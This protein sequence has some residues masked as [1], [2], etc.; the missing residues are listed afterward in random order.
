MFCSVSIVNCIVSVDYYLNIPN[1][2]MT[3]TTV[4]HE[5]NSISPKQSFNSKKADT[6]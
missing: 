6:G 1:Y 3:K 5:I 2:T 4:I